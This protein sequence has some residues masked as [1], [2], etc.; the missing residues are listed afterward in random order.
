[1][2]DQLRPRILII[3]D[4][5][6]IGELLRR[7]F[8]ATG[9]Y[10]V[11]VQTDPFVAVRRAH[12]FKPDVL[13]L[14]VNMPGVNGLEVARSIR[15]EPWLRHRPIIFY[16]G[17]PDTKLACFKAGSDGPTVFVPKGTALLDL[18]QSVEG[19]IASRLELFRAFQAT[20]AARPFRPLSTVARISAQK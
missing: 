4:E 17:V 11:E 13:I 15:G 1:M 16:T 14:D 5:P 8:E 9:E 3:D 18:R 19:L 6:A 20:S 10:F 12:E 2:I 7:F